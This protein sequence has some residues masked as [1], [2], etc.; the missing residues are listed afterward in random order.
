M[1]KLTTEM[2]T[3]SAAAL[4]EL[5]AALTIRAKD[6]EA[7]QPT[8]TLALAAGV[9]DNSY[10]THRWGRVA[11]YS[12]EGI[13][14]MADGR[15]WRCIGHGP[16]GNAE[17]ISRRGYVEFIPL[18]DAPT[19]GTRTITVAID[20]ACKF[21]GVPLLWGVAEGDSVAAALDDAATWLAEGGKVTQRHRDDAAKLRVTTI[22]WPEAE[23]KPDG[24]NKSAIALALASLT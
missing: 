4:R 10:E 3:M 21:G 2:M 16:T 9:R 17:F 8:I 1:T 15:R 7:Q 13:V 19:T 18:D 11:D 23:V 6:L 24:Q 12:G 14:T 22:Q 20:A 5:A